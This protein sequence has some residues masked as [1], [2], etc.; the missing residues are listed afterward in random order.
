MIPVTKGAQPRDSYA[1][2]DLSLD[3]AN[4]VKFSRGR[5]IDSLQTPEALRDWLEAGGLLERAG[6]ADAMLSPAVARIVLTEAHRLRTEVR[7]LF[8]AHS[9]RSTPSP[10]TLYALNRV[11]DSSA[12]T[13]VLETVDEGLILREIERGDAAIVLLA[14]IALAAA[15]LVTRVD[16]ARLGECAAP[17]CGT[18]FVDTS[19]G[20]RRRWCSMARCGNRTKAARHRRKQALRP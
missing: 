11:L 13:R 6:D 4:T 19:K 5:Q 16:P 9:A 7:Q 8:E 1:S 15:R 14:P 2:G 18:W 3:F 17:E 10:A 20:G 12:R